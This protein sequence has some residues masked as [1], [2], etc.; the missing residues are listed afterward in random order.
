MKYSYMS[1]STPT[2][3]LAQ[4][5]EA[6]RRYG[7]DGIEPRLDAGHAHGVEV[8]ATP[9]QRKAVRQQAA[10]SGV[11]LACLATSLTYAD[12]AA[13]AAMVQQTRE[14][15]DLAADVGAPAIRVF[16]GAIKGGLDRGAAIDLVGR[17]LGEVAE[18][19]ARRG[20][21][22]CMETHDSWCDPSHV[23]AVMRKAGHPAIAVNWD[24][25][26][27][28]RTARKTIDESFE[29]LKPWIR[30]L[31]VHD[32][33]IAE[34]LT[35]QPI[36]QGAIDH[37]R[38]IELLKTIRYAGFISGEWIGWE[39]AEVHLPREVATLRR[40]E[41]E[42]C[43]S[44]GPRQRLA[45]EPSAATSRPASPSPW[46]RTARPRPAP[47]TPIPRPAAGARTPRQQERTCHSERSA[48]PQ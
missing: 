27:P 10:A 45:G 13:T 29:A 15:I 39:P 26:H 31:H 19:A 2:F 18:H 3:T 9:D 12:P 21:A 47:H 4:M 23:A 28:V 8:S 48:A 35:M 37:R 42:G 40:Y 41:S 14:R 36:G 38:A 44:D 30:H 46:G 7:Y 1:F 25:M 6:A 34:P 5:L 17:S 11:S 43:P 32:G 33:T 16:G 20:V 24:I 22:V